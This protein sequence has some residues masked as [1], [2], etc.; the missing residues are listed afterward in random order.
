MFTSNTVIFPE[1]Q[2]SPSVLIFP[3]RSI[4]VPPAPNPPPT[5]NSFPVRMVK[6]LSI[7]SSFNQE[8]FVSLMIVPL[9]SSVMLPVIPSLIAASCV[10][11]WPSNDVFASVMLF[12]IDAL[13]PLSDKSDVKFAF[14]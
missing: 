8:V 4:V 9:Y 5:V 6:S 11:K 12:T 14:W 7:L 1:N 10:F 3:S 2:I 13:T